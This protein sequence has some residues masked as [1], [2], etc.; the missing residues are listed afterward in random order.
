MPLGESALGRQNG[1]KE[2][3]AQC[4]TEF[5]SHITTNGS[6]VCYKGIPLTHANEK[7]Q[8]EKLK[9]SYTDSV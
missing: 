1:L 8:I 7:S 3:K 9:V 5:N 2:V 6:K 4:E